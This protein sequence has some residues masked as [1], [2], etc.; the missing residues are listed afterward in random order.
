MNE[1]GTIYFS[2]C[3]NCGEPVQ[4]RFL[5]DRGWCPMCEEQ[6]IKQE[7]EDAELDED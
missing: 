3:R 7:Q 6:E 4:R 2:R 1:T 5:D